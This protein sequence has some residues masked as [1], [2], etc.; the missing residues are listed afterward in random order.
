E[1]MN[2]N[3]RGND[4]ALIWI[5]NKDRKDYTFKDLRDQSNQFLNILRKYG[6]KKGDKM[7]AQLPLLPINWISYLACIK[8]GMIII[9]TATTM[10]VRGMEFRFKSL[11][12]EVALADPEN[13]KKIDQAEEKFENN[14][15]LKLI[16][17]GNRKGWVNVDTMFDEP[18]TAQSENTKADDDLFYFFTSGTTGMP[19]V[20]AHTHFTY[21]VGH[22]T[23]ASWIG[24]KKGDLHYNISQPGWAKFFWSS[25]FAPW[26]MGAT[27]LGYHIDR[28]DPI[29]Q[30]TNIQDLKV[31]TFCAPPSALRSLVREDLSVFDFSNLRQCVAAGEP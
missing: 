19:K 1:G 29:E 26:N 9:P 16:V 17:G 6:I 30:L 25:F 3:E 12:P 5:Y 15:K 7:I 27:V 14:I 18:K 8:G 22:L 23:T 31:T 4:K 28:F 21:P 11:F 10:A 2:V 20:V 24:L 13:A